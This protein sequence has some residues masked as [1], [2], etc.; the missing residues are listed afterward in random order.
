MGRSG[1]FGLG[2]ACQLYEWCWSPNSGEDD[3]RFSARR[4]SFGEDLYA[5]AKWLY[6][7]LAG[8]IDPLR[9]YRQLRHGPSHIPVYRRCAERKLSLVFLEKPDPDEKPDGHRTTNIQAGVTETRQLINAGMYGPSWKDSVVIF[10]DRRCLKIFAIAWGLR[11]SYA[12]RCQ[13]SHNFSPA[14]T[15]TV[16]YYCPVSVKT[17]GFV[18]P[19]AEAAML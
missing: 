3:F 15:L 8:F 7:C 19:A 16:A 5:T 6:L 1:R 2:G 17:A 13:P 10:P 18:T 14:A 12:G 11:P 9:Q 4:R